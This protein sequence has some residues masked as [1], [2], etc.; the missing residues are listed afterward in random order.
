MSKG[1]MKG[2]FCYFV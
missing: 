1:R 2:W